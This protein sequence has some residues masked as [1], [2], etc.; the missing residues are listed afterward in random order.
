MAAVSQQGFHA[1]ERIQHLAQPKKTEDVWN[2]SGRLVCGNQETIWPL[3]S[4]AL[5]C[6][7]NLRILDLAKPKK[8]LEQKMQYRPLHVYSCGQDSEIWEQ[9]FNTYDCMPSERILQLSEPKLCSSIY[10][11]RRPRSSPIWSVSPSAL[12]CKASQRILEISQPRGLNPFF[13]LPKEPETPVTRA[14]RTTSASPRTQRLSQPVIKRAI[15]CY[16]NRCME[17]PIRKVTQAALQAIPTPRLEELARPK[18]TS[19]SAPDRNAEWPVTWAA[20]KAMASPRLE[21]LAQPPRRAS[22]D[23]VQFNPEAFTVKE[24]AK[25]ARCTER[26][27]K[28]AEPILR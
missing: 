28:L 20:K 6:Q 25:N 15:P 4:K 22:A 8:K 27:K 11:E 14:A 10:L 26:I 19:K 12:H 23:V 1:S 5:T 18:V 24:S 17:A 21:A 3:S 7:P 13:V 16:E 2:Y 9:P